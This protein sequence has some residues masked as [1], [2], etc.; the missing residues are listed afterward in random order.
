MS[1]RRGGL[2]D[3]DEIDRVRGGGWDLPLLQRVVD[4]VVFHY[5]AAGTSRECFRILHDEAGLSAHFHIQTNKVA[6]GPAFDWERVL[7][8]LPPP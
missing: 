1:L 7:K 8:Q 2:S 6:P 5:D 3:D 4:Q